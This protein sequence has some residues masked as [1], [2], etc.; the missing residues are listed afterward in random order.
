MSWTC[1][2]CRSTFARHDQCHS[3]DTEELDGQL[4]DRPERLRESF[5]K[6]VGSLPSDVQVEPL[7]SVI[8]LSAQRTFA[9]ITVQG[10]DSC[11]ASFRESALDSARVVKIDHASARKVGSAEVDDELQQW[12]RQAHQL[13]AAGRSNSA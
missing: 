11:L 4:A 2:T 3:H 7:S 1:P 6:I 5:D 9:Y 12:R 10:S 8:V 13:C